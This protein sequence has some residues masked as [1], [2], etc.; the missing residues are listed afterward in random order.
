MESL[1]ENVAR[2]T[3][4]FKLVLKVKSVKAPITQLAVVTHPT[5]TTLF[6]QHYMSSSETSLE[7]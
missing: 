7:F 2:L 3:N 1:K 4:L 6:Y 5:T